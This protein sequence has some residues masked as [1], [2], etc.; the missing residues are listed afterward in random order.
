M[1]NDKITISHCTSPYNSS[2]LIIICLLISRHSCLLSIMQKELLVLLKLVL[3]RC[4]SS[5]WTFCTGSISLRKGSNVDGA[6]LQC[7]VNVLLCIYCIL[8]NDFDNCKYFWRLSQSDR[9][10]IKLPFDKYCTKHCR[11]AF[12]NLATIPVH[13]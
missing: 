13:I 2:K 4:N 10:I 7:G 9:P 5:L 1:C 11:Q 8:G 12:E 3:R 6:W